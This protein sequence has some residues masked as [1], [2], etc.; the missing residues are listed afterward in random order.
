MISRT[1]AIVQFLLF[2]VHCVTGLVMGIVTISSTDP[3]HPMDYTGYA[4]EAVIIYV[5][6]VLVL[7]FATAIVTLQVYW[8]TDAQPKISRRENTLL[9]CALYIA[10]VTALTTYSYI[11]SIYNNMVYFNAA[12]VGG[13]LSSTC[14]VPV[15]IALALVASSTDTPEK[16]N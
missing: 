12:N 15:L 7:N 6:C 14:G 13:L 8:C 1:Y 3:E 2:L 11:A 9:V 4:S 16:I 5:F 10:T